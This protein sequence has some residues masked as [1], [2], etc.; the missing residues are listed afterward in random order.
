MVREQR[1][2]SNGPVGMENLFPSTTP[3][4]EAIKPT[5]D[6]H[7]SEKE[8][9][10]SFQKKVITAI[11]RKNAFLLMSLVSLPKRKACFGAVKRIHDNMQRNVRRQKVWLRDFILKQSYDMRLKFANIV[12]RSPFLKQNPYFQSLFA[13]VVNT[14]PREQ[15][16]LSALFQKGLIMNTSDGAGTADRILLES[17]I[18]YNAQVINDEVLSSETDYFPSLSSSLPSFRFPAMENETP[19]PDD[20]QK[21]PHDILN[22][23]TETVHSPSSF[24]P[25]SSPLLWEYDESHLP[26]SAL[27]KGMKPSDEDFNDNILSDLENLSDAAAGDF[28]SPCFPNKSK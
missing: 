23:S 7:R 13:I 24:P 19:Y 9:G 20:P 4:S 12:A 2:L 6:H 3:Q 28:L 10:R 8:M 26:N 22:F 11:S 18:L 25:F 5:S 17:E 21:T 15:G 27:L 14:L 1:F 16:H